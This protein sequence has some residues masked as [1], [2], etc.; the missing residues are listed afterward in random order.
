MCLK[1]EEG[2]VTAHHVSSVLDKETSQGVPPLA[3]LRYLIPMALYHRASK[4]SAP[5]LEIKEYP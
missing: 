1:G 4:G 2:R 5:F 3:N